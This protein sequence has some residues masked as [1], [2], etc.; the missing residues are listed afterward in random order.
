LTKTELVRFRKRDFEVA[1]MV[2]RTKHPSSI[3]DDPH[4]YMEFEYEVGRV[5]DQWT[6]MSR[7][8][9]DG[10]ELMIDVIKI[11]F[12]RKTVTNCAWDTDAR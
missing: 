9:T 3:G 4:A 8:D 7:R 10:G 1:V 12:E 5:I 6:D 11:A 2:L